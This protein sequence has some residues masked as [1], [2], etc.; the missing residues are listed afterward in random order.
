M[1]TITQVREFTLD[2]FSPQSAFYS[3]TGLLPL[4]AKVIVLNPS[5]VDLEFFSIPRMVKS[6]AL[7]LHIHARTGK[8]YYESVKHNYARTVWNTE[9][10]DDCVILGGVKI[11]T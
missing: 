11:R 2:Y 8:Q 7:H 9:M 3:F 5:F 4:I 10:F 6:N 1:F